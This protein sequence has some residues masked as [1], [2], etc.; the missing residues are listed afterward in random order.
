MYKKKLDDNTTIMLIGI[1]IVTF[2]AR[3]VEK[4][5]Q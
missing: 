2:I 3:I 1:R 5:N 4:N